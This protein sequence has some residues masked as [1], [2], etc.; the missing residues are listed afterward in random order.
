M[1]DTDRWLIYSPR[2]TGG[3]V[4]T[5]LTTDGAQRALAR[6]GNRD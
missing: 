1:R 6:A 4:A 2:H 3:P 5:A